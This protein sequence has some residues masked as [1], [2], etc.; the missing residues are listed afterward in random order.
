MMERI[1]EHAERE[2][3]KECCGVIL[4]SMAKDPKLSA[5]ISC[6]N[7]QDAMHE[8][9]SCGFSRT[10]ET[11]FFIDPAELL[12]IHKLGR[13]RNEQIRVIYH[14]HIDCG[15]Y[16]S[17]EDKRNALLECGEPAYPDA[18]YLVLS[19]L[20]RKVEQAKLFFWDKF[21]RDFIE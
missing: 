19:V 3:P 5:V 16:F 14:S 9:D 12:R 4:G 17:D 8:A 7:I 15:A 1:T 11:A 21:K 13:E 20:K 10:S 6:T 18:Q 2:Y